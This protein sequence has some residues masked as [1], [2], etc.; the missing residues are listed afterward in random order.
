MG[1]NPKVQIIKGSAVDALLNKEVDVIGHCCNCRNRFGGG[2]AKEIRIRIPEA[3]EADR[4]LYFASANKGFDTSESNGMRPVNEN[5]LGFI[6]F[7]SGVYNLYGQSDRGRDGTRKVN[8]GAIASALNA[9][10]NK[11]SQNGFLKGLKIGFPY[12]MACHR[13][14]GD[15]SIVQELIDFTFRNHTVFYYQYEENEDQ[16]KD[17]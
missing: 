16:K 8:Y 13:G 14:G 10:E 5:L 4:Q 1:Q 7:A 17:L 15:W 2:V 9:M 12:N 11:L 6:S 3:Y